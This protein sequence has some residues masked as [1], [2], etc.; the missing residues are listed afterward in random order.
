MMVGI[1]RSRAH[2]ASPGFGCFRKGFECRATN[3]AAGHVGSTT[4]GV[5]TRVR[6]EQVSEI[7]KLKF[8]VSALK[9]DLENSQQNMLSVRAPYDGVVISLAQRNSGSVVQN[10]QELCQLAR[11]DAKPHARLLLSETGLPKLAVGQRVRFFFDAF[12]YQRYGAVDAKLNWISPST[13]STADGSHF[14]GLLPWRKIRK[15]T[16]RCSRGSECEAKLASLSAGEP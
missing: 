9:T 3:F 13:V 1:S 15:L 7:E 8:R 10:G 12:P 6:D 4:D 16:A 14:V 2:S 5:G 11:I